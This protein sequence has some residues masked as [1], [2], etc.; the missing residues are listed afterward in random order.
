MFAAMW[1]QGRRMDDPA[2][3]AAVLAAAGLDGAALVAAA[4]SGE[5]K[6][7]LIANTEQAHARGAFGAPS[8][9]VDGELYFGK[10][11]LRDI[12]DRLLGR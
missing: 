9:F 10:E 4:Q 5:V 2:E 7:Q 12:E 6:A 1:E 8:F 3:I 11:R